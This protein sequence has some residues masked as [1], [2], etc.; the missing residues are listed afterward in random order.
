MKGG[1]TTMELIRSMR[2]SRPIMA[3]RDQ[4]AVQ[5][6]DP[7]RRG[8]GSPGETS[9]VAAGGWLSGSAVAVA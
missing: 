5:I 6:R 1:R 2:A 3:R 4:V 9:R 7:P 8:V